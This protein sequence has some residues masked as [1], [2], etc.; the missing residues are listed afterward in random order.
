MPGSVP[1]SSS[2]K[3]VPRIKRPAD[4]GV[5]KEHL[6]RADEGNHSAL[7]A[8]ANGEQKGRRV[9]LPM[10][11]FLMTKTCQRAIGKLVMLVLF[12]QTVLRATGRTGQT[13]LKPP[14]SVSSRHEQ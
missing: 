1:F 5:S 8:S 3:P 9:Q 12:F 13:D 6:P 7:E 14:S 11:I 2:S 4:D 10:R